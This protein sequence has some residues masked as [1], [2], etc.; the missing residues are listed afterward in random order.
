MSLSS[1]GVIMAEK[2]LT[3][4]AY[5]QMKLQ[6]GVDQLNADFITHW[7][8]GQNSCR[9]DCHYCEKARNSG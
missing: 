6:E 5:I 2:E 8:T 4:E 3:L 9:K 1:G 7:V